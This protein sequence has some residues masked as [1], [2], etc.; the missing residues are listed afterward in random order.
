M[1]SVGNIVA[2]MFWG[3]TAGIVAQWAWRPVPAEDRV[4]IAVP[5]IELARPMLEQQA[6]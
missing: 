2:L 3:P 6:K 4:E 1:F 5:T